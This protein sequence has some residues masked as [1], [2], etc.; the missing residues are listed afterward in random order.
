ME[1]TSLLPEDVASLNKYAF[2]WAVV[3][4]YL[5]KYVKKWAVVDP[6]F[7]KYVNI[8][9]YL[10]NYTPANAHFAW[11]LDNIN[12]ANPNRVLIRAKQLIVKTFLSKW[13]TKTDSKT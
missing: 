10:I 3:D 6:Y 7:I 9:T 11:Q 8:L 5:I 4:I 2:M 1:W 13:L 12:E